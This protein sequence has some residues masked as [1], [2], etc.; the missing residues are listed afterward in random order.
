MRFDGKGMTKRFK[1]KEALCNECFFKN[2]KRAF[3]DFCKEHSSLFL[4]GF[5]CNDEISVLLR[6]S[7]NDGD[8]RSRKEK[9]LSLFSSEISVRF[10][11][12]C[13]KHPPEVS[14][15][16]G[17]D[18][19][20]VFDARIFEIAKENISTYFRLRQAFG[21]EHTLTRIKNKT[22]CEYGIPSAIEL[23]K[24]KTKLN[25]REVLFGIFFAPKKHLYP[26]E[27][28][29]REEQLKKLLFG[30]EI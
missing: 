3:L 19:V 23:L 2:I 6:A 10:D 22:K 18:L 14:I 30:G 17:N 4:F 29:T 25:P 8:D 1:P 27:L 13:S 28:K 20:N 16:N 5:Q 26:I 11:R 12:L 15:E 7:E 9:M 21:I 24:E